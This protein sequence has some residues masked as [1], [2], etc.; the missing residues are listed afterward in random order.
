MQREKAVWVRKW[1]DIPST[2]EPWSKA[3]YILLG[4]NAIIVQRADGQIVS[5]TV[6]QNGKRRTCIG[7]FRNV[8]EKNEDGSF[9]LVGVIENELKFISYQNKNEEEDP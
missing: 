2:V 7:C 3:R 1:Q 8:W 9:A 6:A 5:Q 4:T